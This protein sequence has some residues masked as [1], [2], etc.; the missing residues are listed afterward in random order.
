M[1]QNG[2]IPSAVDYQKYIR[3]DDLKRGLEMMF[4]CLRDYYERLDQNDVARVL[5]EI[6]KTK[7][8]NFELYNIDK[9]QRSGMESPSSVSSNGNRSRRDLDFN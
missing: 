5:L 4:S 1:T 3:E 2:I 6:E 7:K 8:D 9:K